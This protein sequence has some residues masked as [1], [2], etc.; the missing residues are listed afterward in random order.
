[1]HVVA[2]P[3]EP[4]L[5][6]QVQD[7]MIHLRSQTSRT[8]LAEVVHAELMRLALACRDLRIQLDMQG[9]QMDDLMAL[10]EELLR[11][12]KP[13]PIRRFINWLNERI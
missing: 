3:G 7:A 13:G 6:K 8:D 1:M 12:L 2:T 9:S 11:Q 5:S 10:N 4:V